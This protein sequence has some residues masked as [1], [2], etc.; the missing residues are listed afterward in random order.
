MSEHGGVD[1]LLAAIQETLG[2]YHRR[3]EAIDE[4]L[5][6]LVHRR[7]EIVAAARLAVLEQL[8]EEVK[9]NLP[10]VMTADTSQLLGLPGSEHVAELA[11]FAGREFEA[12]KFRLQDFH[13]E[14]EDIDANLAR[15]V[16]KREELLAGARL[17]LADRVPEEIRGRVTDVLPKVAMAL[18]C[19]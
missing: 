17:S 13:S 3:I 10:E 8:P 2:E 18:A 6:R 9:T 14:I 5:S 15:M 19:R 12:V 16:H 11:A 1:P 4:D 7:E